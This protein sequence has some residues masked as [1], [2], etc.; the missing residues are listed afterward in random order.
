MLETTGVKEAGRGGLSVWHR[1][2][3]RYLQKISYWQILSQARAVEN[4]C[5]VVATNSCG[6]AGETQRRDECTIA[7][8]DDEED[9]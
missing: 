2:S 1:K 5:F 6:A 4:Q 7:H 8:H 3:G 9:V